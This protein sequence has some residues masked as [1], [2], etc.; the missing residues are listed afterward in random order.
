MCKWFLSWKVLVES[1]RCHVVKYCLQITHKSWA[2]HACYESFLFEKSPRIMNKCRRKNRFDWRI[3]LE[4]VATG[5]CHKCLQSFGIFGNRL[6]INH[7]GLKVGALFSIPE[8]DSYSTRGTNS[9]Y[10][11]SLRFSWSII[12]GP[13]NSNR[14]QN[15]GTNIYLSCKHN[16]KIIVLMWRQN[17]VQPKPT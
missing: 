5:G 8:I 7:T 9:L 1:K 17:N 11:S 2:A 12:I 6:R 13:I 10:G 16:C 3:H 15:F 4:S 14:C